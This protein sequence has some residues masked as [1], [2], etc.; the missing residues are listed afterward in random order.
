MMNK[1]T[2]N[3]S[4][5]FLMAIVA[6]SFLISACENK[7]T[8]TGDPPFTLSL[9]S[10]GDDANAFHWFFP[11][12]Y[13][14][15]GEIALCVHQIRFKKDNSSEEPG[16]NI[17][18]NIKEMIVTSS[19]GTDISTLNLSPGTYRRVD[20]MVKNN[21]G[22]GNSIEI[23]NTNGDF[24]LSSQKILRFNG[25]FE[26][27]EDLEKLVLPFRDFVDFFENVSSDNE[28]DNDIETITAE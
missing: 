7:G 1:K 27:T 25:T 18:I 12:A 26:V 2:N 15:E 14:M 9:S 17:N 3:R 8:E 6:S 20:L 24:S 22:T 16:E 5:L 19:E 21:C 4:Y 10:Y 28:L 11:K 23:S 13:A